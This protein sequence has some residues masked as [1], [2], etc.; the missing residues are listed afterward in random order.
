[1]E[2]LYKIFHH[3]APD[4]ATTERLG[5]KLSKYKDKLKKV[6]FIN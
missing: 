2:R 5:K 6:Q 1:M 4:K 3:T